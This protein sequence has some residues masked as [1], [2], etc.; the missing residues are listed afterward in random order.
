[1]EHYKYPPG[2]AKSRRKPRRTRASGLALPVPLLRSYTRLRDAMTDT[3]D[4]GIEA[5]RAAARLARLDTSPAEEEALC[6]AVARMLQHFAALQTVPVDGVEALRTPADL[7][8]RQR[9]SLRPDETRPSLP[10]ETLLALAPRHDD[11][12]YR[13]PKAVGGAG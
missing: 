9:G 6:T 2:P 4:Q 13:V 3:P 11:E 8:A 1:M 5:I 7:D 10:R 12:H